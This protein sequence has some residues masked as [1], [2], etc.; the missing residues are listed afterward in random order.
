[1]PS[2]AS[3]FTVDSAAGF[4]PGDP[5]LIQRPVTEA[6]IRFMGMDTLA[7]TAS[8][9]RGSRP[10]PSSTPIASITSVAGTRVTLDVPL[11][12]SFD[13]AYLNPPGT[14]VVKYTFPGRI[15]QVG[16]ESLR[17]TVPAQDKPISES[18]YTLLRMNAVSDGWV[19]D[20]VSIDTQ[21]SITIGHTVRRVTLENVHIRHTLPFTA[22]PRRPISRSRARR[23][24]SIARA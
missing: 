13:A 11:S 9:R 14:T 6:W 8:R 3:S 2:G 10:A 20:V 15:E 7:A 5:V 23:F 4:K 12:D 19:R 21:N 17:V 18:Q 1:M 16:F 24:C 22:P